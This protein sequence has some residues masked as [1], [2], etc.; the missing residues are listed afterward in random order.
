MCLSLQTIDSHGGCCC[1]EGL[2]QWA[3]ERIAATTEVSVLSPTA[4]CCGALHMLLSAVLCASLSHR[5]QGPCG[6]VSTSLTTAA[7]LAPQA[8]LMLQRLLC[9]VAFIPFITAGDPDLDTTAEAL[10]RLDR[11][12]ASVIELGVPYTVCVC[13][14]RAFTRLPLGAWYQTHA[15]PNSYKAGAV[16]YPNSAFCRLQGPTMRQ[17]MQVHEWPWFAVG[18]PGGWPCHSVG[19]HAGAGRRHDARRGAGHAAA[20]VGS[21]DG[22]R[23]HVYILQ[24][25]HGAGGGRLLPASP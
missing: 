1:R 18:P 20:G 2:R 21:A 13:D 19:V 11:N 5:P 8:L 12:G 22:A 24:P 14:P 15:I 23:S 16:A 17:C 3:I 6:T 25:H 10:L 9:R 7:H 4:F